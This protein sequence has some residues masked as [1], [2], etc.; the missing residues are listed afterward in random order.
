[1]KA[2]GIVS[3]RLLW[4]ICIVLFMSFCLVAQ[5][6]EWKNLLDVSGPGQRISGW[7]NQFVIHPTNPDIIYAATEGAGFLISEDGGKR[8]IPKNEGLTM[9]AEGTV[10]GYHVRCLAVDPKKPDTVYVGMAAFGTFK[11]TNGGSSWTDMNDGLGDTFTKV[12][13]IDPTNPDILYLGTDGGGVHRRNLSSGRWGEISEG[14]KNTYIKTIVMDPKDP[15]TLYVGTDGGIAKTV[16][17]GNLWTIINNGLTSRFV[18]TLAIDSKN[19][20]VLYAG[21]DGGGLFK[22]TDGGDSW[23]PL[24]GEI[25]MSRS[26]S[27]D[28]GGT[29][30]ETAKAL[31][32]SSIV[33]NPINP[34]IVYAADSNGVFRSADSGNTWTKINAGLTSTNVKCLGINPNPPVKIYASTADAKIFVYTEE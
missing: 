19:P 26:V 20:K 12:M 34:S 33:V 6:A 31:V 16:D 18:L 28:F 27:E 22:S 23:T 8:W 5:A 30:A 15:K 21:T 11:S 24:G 1:M 3:G 29:D 17:G 4:I 32:V 9:A 10:S 13:L 14:L 25:W 2:L 7:V